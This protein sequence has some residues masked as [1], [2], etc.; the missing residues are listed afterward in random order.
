MNKKQELLNHFSNIQ[1]AIAEAR[2]FANT[3][4][5]EDITQ[6]E[7]TMSPEEEAQLKQQF[8]LLAEYMD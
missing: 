1:S 6:M 5:Q 2:E 3:L 7:Q 8:A 4:T